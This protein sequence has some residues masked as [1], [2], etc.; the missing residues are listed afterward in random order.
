MEYQIIRMVTQGVNLRRIQRNDR[1]V[2]AIYWIPETRTGPWLAAQS[3]GAT[4]VS[5]DSPTN[6]SRLPSPRRRRSRTCASIR[7][8]K[9]RLRHPWRP[10]HRPGGDPAHGTRCRSAHPADGDQPGVGTAA[11]PENDCGPGSVG[12]GTGATGGAPAGGAVTSW[13]W[14]GTGGWRC[15]WIRARGGGPPRRRRPARGGARTSRSPG[16]PRP[17]PCTARSPRP[18]RP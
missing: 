14:P 4:P 13:C 18:R 5:E 6:G 11:W 2:R 3:A 17:L 7:A 9:R 1:Q 15:A 8:A 10:G 16:W 12:D